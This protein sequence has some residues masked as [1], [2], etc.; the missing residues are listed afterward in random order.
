VKRFEEGKEEKPGPGDYN[1]GNYYERHHKV[2]FYKSTVPRFTSKKSNNSEV[3]SNVSTDIQNGEKNEK[4]SVNFCR[5]P[6]IFGS[7]TKRFIEK[8]RVMNF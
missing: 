8:K 7:G 5:C 1:P 2:A 3:P 6:A 4:E